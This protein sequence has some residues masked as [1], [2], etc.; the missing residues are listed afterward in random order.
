MLISFEPFSEISDEWREMKRNLADSSLTRLREPAYLLRAL[1]L[2]QNGKESIN[3]SESESF[4][5]RK[6]TYNEVTKFWS[7]RLD[8]RSA[9][10][11]S[12]DGVKAGWLIKELNDSAK[13]L[14]A[15]SYEQSASNKKAHFRNLYFSR[16][17]KISPRIIRTLD[18]S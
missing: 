6:I 1:A 13:W 12:L 8:A 18:R 9:I 16:F 4:K 17:L 15:L 11:H 5:P 3:K 2:I 10:E 14:S 7:N